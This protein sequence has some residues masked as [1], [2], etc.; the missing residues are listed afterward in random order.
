MVLSDE[1]GYF[2]TASG[3]W[4]RMSVSEVRAGQNINTSL[5]YAVPAQGQRMRMPHDGTSYFSFFF[6]VMYRFVVPKSIVQCPLSTGASTIPPSLLASSKIKKRT[7]CLKI[8]TLV[9]RSSAAI[10]P[11]TKNW[12]TVTAVRSLA[13]C[14]CCC[15]TSTARCQI[16]DELNKSIFQSS[17]FYSAVVVVVIAISAYVDTEL[18]L[19]ETIDRGRYGSYLTDFPSI[20]DKQKRTAD[21][22]SNYCFALISCASRNEG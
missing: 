20:A 4:F 8:V 5:F 14:L 3:Y 9:P 7:E 16:T 18:D 21:A 1:A 22:S 13:G 2:R 11:V 15:Y 19:K 10:D 17:L 6:A 12:V